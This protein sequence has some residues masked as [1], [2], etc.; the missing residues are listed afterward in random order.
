MDM[1]FYIIT[2][3]HDHMNLHSKD[4]DMSGVK[5][6]IVNTIHLARYWCRAVWRG[7]G[8]AKLVLPLEVRW[9]TLSGCLNS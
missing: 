2:I 8:G 3:I 9:N 4:V 1:G 6:R 7:G 5:E